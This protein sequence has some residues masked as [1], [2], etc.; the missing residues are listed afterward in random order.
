M[1]LDDLDEAVEKTDLYR[2]DQND[3]E[4]E[5]VMNISSEEDEEIISA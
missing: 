3:R 2:E 4:C 1:S 5:V